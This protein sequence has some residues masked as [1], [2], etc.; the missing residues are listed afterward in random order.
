MTAFPDPQFF[1]SLTSIGMAWSA[2]AYWLMFSSKGQGI[3][4]NPWLIPLTFATL[5]LSLWLVMGEMDKLQIMAGGMMPLD[6]QYGY[7]HAEIIAFAESLG[8]DGRTAYAV[9]QL[10][11]DAL[12]PPA[13]IC[14]LMSVYRS[15]VY[16]TA[17]QR[18]LNI[19]AFS[20]FT[21][22]LIANTFMPVIMHNYPDNQTGM[23]PLLYSIIPIMDFV[24]YTSHGIAWLVIFAAWLWQMYEWIALRLLDGHSAEEAR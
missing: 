12:A 11:A 1:S 3:L 20:Y 5:G 2:F 6:G 21:S 9:F 24:K 18:T 23:L 8:P 7:G 17:A 14:F 15:T 22:V 16:S 4:K 13:F 10:G 19:L